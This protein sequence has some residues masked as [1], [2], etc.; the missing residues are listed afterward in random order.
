MIFDEVIKYFSFF[1]AFVA[2]ILGI[3]K[4]IELFRNKPILR[5]HG[6]GGIKHN[7][8]KITLHAMLEISNV[9]RQPTIIKEILYDILNDK[10]QQ[11]NVHSRLV[12]MGTMKMQLL[13]N[14]YISRVFQEKID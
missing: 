4:I 1:G 3:L 2:I 6:S 8:T 13:P 7:N 12:N 9:G 14:E 10:K 11:I 5:G